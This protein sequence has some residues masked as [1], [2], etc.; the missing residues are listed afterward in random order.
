M[1]NNG[2][3]GTNVLRVMGPTASY[4]SAGTIEKIT[5]VSTCQ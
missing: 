4:L 1:D 5:S 2:N 3:G